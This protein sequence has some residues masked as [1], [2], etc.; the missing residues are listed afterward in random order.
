MKV[1]FFLLFFSFLMHAGEIS[2]DVLAKV[3]YSHSF[4]LENA[5]LLLQRQEDLL[6]D[7]SMQQK[8]LKRKIKKQK[9]EIRTLE[10]MLLGT[11]FMRGV[12]LRLDDLEVKYRELLETNIFLL[13]AL[14]RHD[15]QPRRP[16]TPFPSFIS[17][18]VT[19][20]LQLE[21]DSF[22]SEDRMITG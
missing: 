5:F 20:M 12:F 10:N 11:R 4:V 16:A 14:Q 9:Q 13:E 8:R 17:S 15:E 18:E 6:Y 19:E 7:L 1:F 22:E 21:D 2:V 3:I